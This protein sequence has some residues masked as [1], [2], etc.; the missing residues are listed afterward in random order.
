MVQLNFASLQNMNHK[1]L[2]LSW[3]PFRTDV[4]KVGV[5]QQMIDKLKKKSQHIQHN[6]HKHI[7]RKLLKISALNKM[8][9]NLKQYIRPLLQ[10]KEKKSKRKTKHIGIEEFLPKLLLVSFPTDC[11]PATKTV[12][13]T[14]N[15][16]WQ[17]VLL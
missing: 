5:R 1:P 12:T 9:L 6:P 17:L 7:K 11:L 14:L 3:S 15:I 2:Q 4:L 16:G 10:R 13:N 8:K